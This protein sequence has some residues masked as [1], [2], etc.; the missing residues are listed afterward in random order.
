MKGVSFL[1]LF[2]KKITG[3]FDCK[4]FKFILS[5]LSKLSLKS[6][7]LFDNKSIKLFSLSIFLLS[8][9]IVGSSNDKSIILLPLSSL[10]SFFLF[11][12]LSSIII[13]PFFFN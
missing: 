8:K 10:N 9:I 7:S 6:S 1:F 3:S 11:I 12:K 13:F 4:S 2:S 5:L